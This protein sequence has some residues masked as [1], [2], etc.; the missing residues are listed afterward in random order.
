MDS[1]QHVK[2]IQDQLMMVEH[3]VQISVMIEKLRV[4]LAFVSAVPHTLGH[5]EKEPDVDLISV[6]I[7]K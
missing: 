6:N 3:A 7:L 2:Y 5:N 4:T 1:V